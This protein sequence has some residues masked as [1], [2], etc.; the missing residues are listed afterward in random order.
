M[1]PGVQADL[2][3]YRLTNRRIVKPIDGQHKVAMC[4]LAYRQILETN[5]LTN[6]RIVKPI[7]GQHKVAKCH[8]AYRLV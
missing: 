8:L 5:R 1:L 2:E 7:D 6:R 4:H 3:T